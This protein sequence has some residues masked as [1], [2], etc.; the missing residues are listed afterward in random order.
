M[1]AMMK[2]DKDLMAKC[3]KERPFKV[4]DGYFEHFHEQLMSQLP[5]TAPTAEPASKVTLMTRIKPWI[6]MAAMFAGII[7][8]VQGLMYV[9]ETQLANG[10][11]SAE[12]IYN[13]EADHF[14]SSS[15]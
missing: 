8:M 12:E 15:L 4:P 3:G 10:I 14:M 9:Q 11:A 5:E 7:F 2:D 1:F 13:D 6:Y